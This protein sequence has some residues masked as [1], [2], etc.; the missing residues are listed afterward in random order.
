MSAKEVPGDASGR[1]ADYFDHWYADMQTH[2]TKDSLLARRF[3]LPADLGSAGA[4]HWDAV[5]EI[6]RELRVPAGGLLVDLACGRGGYGIEVARRSEARLI[7][8]DFSAVALKR[9]RA[10]ADRRLL[11]EQ[12][13]FC[14]GSLTDTALPTGAAAAVMCTDSVQ[15]AEPPVAALREIRRALRPGGRVALTTWQPVSPGDP[16]LSPRLRYLDLDA[17]LQKAGFDEVRV[18]ERPTWRAA[19][20]RLWEEAVSMPNEN[21]DNALASL[22][23]EGHRSLETFDALRRVAAYATAP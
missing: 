12:A 3:E 13:E 2:T 19:E 1:G 22:Q 21:N 8:V 17:D 10:I 4:L 6:T 9:A 18:E 23:H 16:R 7:G 5:L 15:F 20:R 11:P 14:L